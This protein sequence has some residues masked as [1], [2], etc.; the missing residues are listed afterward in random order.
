LA[1][2]AQVSVQSAGLLGAAGLLAAGAP[3]G[4]DPPLAAAPVEV[5]VQTPFDD[6]GAAGEVVMH[7]GRLVRGGVTEA[8]LHLNPAEMG[9]IRVQI[10]L[11]GSQARIDFAASHA[12]TR[13]LLESSLPALAQSLQDDG[14]TLADSRVGTVTAADAQAGAAASGGSSAR[15]E[16]SSGEPGRGA[17]TRPGGPDA[18]PVQGRR[19]ADEAD[20]GAGG[21]RPGDV[22]AGRAPSR[23]RALDLYA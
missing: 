2:E 6:P 9:P 5:T 12:A 17:Q 14:L 10:T 1:L 13:E 8:S 23:V 16:G 7:M 11:D 15:G 3:G 19:D 18:A 22:L 21:T 20:R 4:A